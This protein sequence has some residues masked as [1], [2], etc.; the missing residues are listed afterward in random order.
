M[1]P[2]IRALEGVKKLNVSRN[3]FFAAKVIFRA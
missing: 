3:K 2:L 1:K